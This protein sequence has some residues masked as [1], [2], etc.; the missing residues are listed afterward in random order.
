VITWRFDAQAVQE[1]VAQGA[2]NIPKNP[3]SPKHHSTWLHQH[4]LNLL[5]HINMILSSVLVFDA[6]DGKESLTSLKEI[7]RLPEINIPL[8]PRVFG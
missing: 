3:L 8:L 1:F 6:Y 7:A 2:T 4:L 5:D